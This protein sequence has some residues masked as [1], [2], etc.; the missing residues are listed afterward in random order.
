MH[1][2]VRGGIETTVFREWSKTNT[3]VES[4]KSI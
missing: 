3:V 1:V 4:D 2:R